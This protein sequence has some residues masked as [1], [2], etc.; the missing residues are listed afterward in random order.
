MIIKKFQLFESK[1]EGIKEQTEKIMKDISN[2]FDGEYIEQYVLDNFANYCDMED[3]EEEGYDDPYKYYTELGAGGNGIENDLIND[4]WEYIKENYDIDL[5][6]DDYTDLRYALEY[7]IKEYFPHYYFKDY[8][9]KSNF[10]KLLDDWDSF[11]ENKSTN[12]EF[13]K[14]FNDIKNKIIE[15][16]PTYNLTNIDLLYDKIRECFYKN[17]NINDTVNYLYNRGWLFTFTTTKD[18]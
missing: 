5:S 16:Y 8:R 3:M 11:N 12:K 17:Y 9:I 14:Y 2:E 4:M 13:K 15:L 7:Y 18:D 6:N 1:K 10:D